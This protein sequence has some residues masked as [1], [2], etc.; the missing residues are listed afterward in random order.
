[1]ASC[2]QIDQ[3]LQPYLDRELAHSDRVILEQHVGECTICAALVRRHQASDAGLFE[4]FRAARLDRDMTDYVLSHLPEMERPQVDVAGLNQRAKAAGH[5]RERVFRLVPIAAAVLLVV[6]AAVLNT[7]W[8]KEGVPAGALGMIAFADG[9]VQR[10]DGESDSSSR[11]RERAGAMNGDRF[12]TGAS[13]HASLMLLGPSEIRVDADSS[14]QVESD[15]RIT[16]DR[17]RILLDIAKTR[18]WFKVLTP[19]GEVTVF[20]T[21]F[22]VEADSGRTTVVVESGEVQLSHRDNPHIFRSIKP[23]QKAYIE[24]GLETVPVTGVD[25]SAELAWGQPLAAPQAMRDYFM[26]RVQPAYEVTEVAAEPGYVLSGGGPLVSITISWTNTSP[27]VR[28][29]DYELFVSTADNEPYFHAHIDGSVFS[30]PRRTEIEIENS[31]DRKAG[32]RT[33]WAKLVPVLNPDLDVK[34]VDTV[35]VSARFLES[36]NG[37]N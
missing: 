14:V 1:M 9:D 31:G 6:L 25:A 23:N 21:R 24:A 15:R 22:S 32:S 20:G 11:V 36:T 8:P 26:A 10:V 17:G 2:A 27:I 33:F 19:M 13:G 7:R 18:R 5:F 3:L 35:S 28:Y 34:R 37:G 29:C 16:L 12:V 4:T 30:D